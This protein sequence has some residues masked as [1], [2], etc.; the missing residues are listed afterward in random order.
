MNTLPT[1]VCVT[2]FLVTTLILGII[3]GIYHG[4]LPDGTTGV[5]MDKEFQTVAEAVCLIRIF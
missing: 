2:I 1:K 4:I 3:L 5:Q